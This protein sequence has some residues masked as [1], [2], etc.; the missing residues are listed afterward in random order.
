M[1]KGGEFE[2][3][4]SKFLS[5]WWTNGDR[6]D[7]FWRTSASGAR[8]TVRAAVFKQTNYEYGDITFT[9]PVG[10]ALL[11]L[12]IIEAKRGYTN[13]SRKLKKEDLV[14]VATIRD[15]KKK[16]KAI[17][18]MV[19][20]TKKGGG[21]DLLDVIDSKIVLDKQTLVDWIYKG[22][23]DRAQAG[24]PYFM[25]IF[26]RDNHL[27][28]VVT[29]CHLQAVFEEHQGRLRSNSL[30]LTMANNDYFITDG[31]SYFDWLQPETVEIVSDM[32]RTRRF[33]G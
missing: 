3:E 4:I 24:A 32:A 15:P 18:A 12:M 20:R 27:M 29:P 2:R 16:V 31:E 25:V 26:R 8:A 21:V 23:V 5:L 14:K 10:K 30:V 17:Q 9:D 33:R 1:G 28:S 13:T 7:V 22:E 6:D 11:D 19:S